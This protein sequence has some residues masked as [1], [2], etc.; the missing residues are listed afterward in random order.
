[1]QGA[2]VSFRASGNNERTAPA[3]VL[4]ENEKGI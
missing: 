3:K 1:M 2:S 4:R